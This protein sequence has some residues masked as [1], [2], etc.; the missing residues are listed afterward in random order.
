MKLKC[1][2]PKLP[3][4]VLDEATKRSVDGIIDVLFRSYAMYCKIR[5]EEGREPMPFAIWLTD[6]RDNMTAEEF[7]KIP[8]M[9]K[10]EYYGDE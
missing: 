1:K 6:V 2:L 9:S 10:A 7:A 8:I 3:Q 5:D 4:N